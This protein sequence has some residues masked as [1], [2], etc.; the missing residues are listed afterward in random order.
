MVH[1][2]VR[3]WHVCHP[4]GVKLHWVENG[5]TLCG[6]S[7]TRDTLIS[8][9]ALL[10]I[11]DTS[12]LDVAM[13]HPGQPK[14]VERLWDKAISRSIKSIAEDRCKQCLRKRAAMRLSSAS[15]CLR[16]QLD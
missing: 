15:E 5:K 8:D 6:K 14:T 10:N 11:T 4:M 13:N 3:G 1:R 2:N 12:W 9:T 16:L 7:L